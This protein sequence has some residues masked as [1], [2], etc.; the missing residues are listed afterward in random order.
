MRRDAEKI[1]E[2]FLNPM[3][4]AGDLALRYPGE[5][6][7]PQQSYTTAATPENRP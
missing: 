7:H 2:R 3:V 4:A 6:N 5:P 1:R